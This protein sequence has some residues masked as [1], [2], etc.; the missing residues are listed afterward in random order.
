[1]ATK[2]MH[3]AFESEGLNGPGVAWGVKCGR[4]SIVYEAMFPKATA[5]RLSELCDA[6]PDQGWDDHCTVLEDEG[7]SLTDPGEVHT[8]RASNQV[9]S[10]RP[11]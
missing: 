11:G 7:Y 5:L 3:E 6:M 8:K 4:G 9:R 2:K 10:R 1:M